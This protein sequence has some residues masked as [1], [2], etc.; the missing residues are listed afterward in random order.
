MDRKDREKLDKNFALLTLECEAVKVVNS[1]LELMSFGHSRK[2]L[3]SEIR[4]MRSHL[5]QIEKLYIE[6]RDE[7][8]K[9]AI[10]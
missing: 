6:I 1:L 2:D 8:L 5:D 7:L 3:E 4:S 9:H 10:D